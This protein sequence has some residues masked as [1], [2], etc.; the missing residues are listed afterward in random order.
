[1]GGIYVS[2]SAIIHTDTLL[3][4]Y[5]NKNYNFNNLNKDFH[6]DLPRLKKAEVK[7]IVFAIYVEENYQTN[8]DG[9]KKT[10]QMVDDFYNIL[11]NCEELVL[12]KHYNDI[13]KIN[14]EDKIAAILAV[15]GAK[16]LYS[17]SALRVFN[18]LGIRLITLTWNHRNQIGDG[19]GV[20]SKCGL[21]SFGKDFVKEMHSL[22][23]IVDV[24]HLNERGFWDVLEISEAPI[25]ASHSNVKNLCNHPRNLNDK[26]I[27]AIAKANGVIGINFYPL[28]LN[29]QEKADIN[30]VFKHIAFIKNLVGIDYVGLGTDFDGISETPKGLSDI[31]KLLNL[32]SILFENG[33]SE[34]E[35]E[36][37]FYKNVYRVFKNVLK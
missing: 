10:I 32:K 9:L 24:S 31:S 30:D 5:K 36:K 17:L 13:L 26:Q 15:E 20:N 21:T 8:R 2:S 1:M 7:L 4:K 22:N 33:Y 16:S 37:I 18:K 14:N 3:N 11:E 29:T 6:I 19:V 35:V 12:A 25:I 23:M 28:F 34:Q 27:K